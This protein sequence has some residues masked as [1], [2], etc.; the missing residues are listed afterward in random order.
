MSFNTAENT[1][2]HF[3]KWNK[4]AVVHSWETM[5]ERSSEGENYTAADMRHCNATG[6]SF[7]TCEMFNANFDQ[8]IFKGTDFS[9]SMMFGAVMTHTTFENCRM[10]WTNLSHANCQ[11]AS[12]KGSYLRRA[13]FTRANLRNADFTGV[14]LDDTIFFGANITGAIMDAKTYRYAVVSGAV[15]DGKIGPS[16]M[17]SVLN[18]LSY[19]AKRYYNHPRV[20]QK[21]EINNDLGPTVHTDVSVRYKEEGKILSLKNFIQWAFDVDRILKGRK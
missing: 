17:D 9:Y 14:H 11:D 19:A 6:G 10:Y 5:H 1:P 16:V 20:F 15:D 7:T 12:F 18:E 8:S 4:N 13:D 3:F 21:P 2:I